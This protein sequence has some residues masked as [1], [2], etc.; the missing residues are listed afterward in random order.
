MRARPRETPATSDAALKYAL[1]SPCAKMPV[2]APLV[3]ARFSRVGSGARGS[4]KFLSARKISLDGPE[5]IPRAHLPAL[6]PH[7]S[8][9]WD[10]HLHLSAQHRA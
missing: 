3:N 1:Y 6:A 9:P 2:C 7:S 4:K 8:M 10:L 5:L